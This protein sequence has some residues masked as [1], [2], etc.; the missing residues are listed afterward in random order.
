MRTGYEAVIA[1]RTTDT[2]AYT[3]KKPGKV[4]K[5][6]P[7]GIIIE[8]E[9]GERVGLRLGRRFGLASGMTVPHDI[10]TFQKEGDTF[11][12]GDCISYNE[13]FFERDIFSPNCV[14]MKNSLVCRAV[15]MESSDT[16][17][18]SSTISP[19]LAKKLSTKVT[20]T[21]TKVVRFDQTVTNVLEEGQAVS[22]DT[23]LC[24]IQS[25]A[26]ANSAAFS[27]ETLETLEALDTGT[28][29]ARVDGVVDAVEVYYHGELLD[30]NESLQ[31]LAKQSNERLKKKAE[32]S[33]TTAFT[34]QVDG[35]F[36]I[37]GTPMPIENVAIRFYITSDTPAG[38]GDKGVVANQ[39]KTVHGAIMDGIYRSEDGQE[40]DLIFGAQSFD[41]RI[42]N[43][44]Y[45]LGMVTTVRQLTSKRAAEM[46]FS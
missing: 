21:I 33:E 29:R 16:L 15:I 45:I 8:Y 25:D 14:V 2:F 40:I 7:K 39:M 43:S 13:G 3:A 42:V 6:N 41:A 1:H 17:E 12:V 24:Y 46:Y 32:Q 36:R 38:V 20:H 5:I 35:G 22:F 37:Q 11:Q 44:P 31:I 34:G 18:D 30:M 9:D 19:K 10:V 26:S 4:L 28:P 23:V 27:D